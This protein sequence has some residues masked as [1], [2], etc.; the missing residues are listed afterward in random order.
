MRFNFNKNIFLNVYTK[1]KKNTFLNK[2]ILKAMLTLSI[3]ILLSKQKYGNSKETE[4]DPTTTLLVI[5]P[6]FFSSYLNNIIKY[7]ITIGEKKEKKKLTEK[8]D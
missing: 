1:L 3:S 7:N 4:I 8:I 6:L 5:L 2:Q